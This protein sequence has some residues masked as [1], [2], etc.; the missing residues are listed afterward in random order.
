MI[1][2]RTPIPHLKKKALSYLEKIHGH[3]QLNINHQLKQ[4]DDCALYNSPRDVYRSLSTKR[5]NFKSKP[6]EKFIILPPDYKTGKLRP[7]TPIKSSNDKS[8][9]YKSQAGSLIIPKVKI[10]YESFKS[11]DSISPRDEITLNYRIKCLNARIKDI[12]KS[13]YPKLRRKARK[14]NKIVLTDPDVKD[15]VESTLKNYNLT[16]TQN[17]LMRK[18][19]D[20]FNN[21]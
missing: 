21:F 19:G 3:G 11:N 6:L 8:F 4:K 14:P 15:S 17:V 5:G 18:W 9:I 1:E 2:S 12:S 7:I 20:F 13:I 16:P 10:I